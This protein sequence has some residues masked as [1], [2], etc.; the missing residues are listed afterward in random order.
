[1]VNRIRKLAQ[2]FFLLLF[3]GLF[4][5]ARFPYE[6]GWPSDI[7]LR[8]SP[9]AALTTALS[10]RTWIAS[11]LPA[12][13]LL[14]LTIPLGRFFC[15]WICPLGTVIDG[16]D[17]CLRRRKPAAGRESVRFRSGK[18]FILVA[19]L[20][21]A[22]FSW[23]AAWFFDPLV[24]LTRV[25]TVSLYPAMALLTQGLFQIGFTSGIAEEQWYTLYAWMQKWLLPVQSVSFEQSI[26][27]LLLFIGVLALGLVSRRFWCRNL[28]PQGALHEQY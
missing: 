19:V 16:S 26:P 4:L 25:L 2:I 3:L 8:T 11:M 13:I 18:F 20:C 27:V 9:L 7:F 24:M 23:Q 15:G 17:R 10:A 5:H 14:L 12:V 1:M 22:L 6:G 28:C 21:A